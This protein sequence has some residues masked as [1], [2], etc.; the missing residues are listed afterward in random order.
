M[1]KARAY[2]LSIEW[3]RLMQRGIPRAKLREDKIKAYIHEDPAVTRHGNATNI[4]ETPSRNHTLPLRG[5]QKLFG[6]A[7]GKPEERSVVHAFVT[8]ANA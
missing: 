5:L 7:W 8:S 1:S 6:L 3:S 4:L 2:A